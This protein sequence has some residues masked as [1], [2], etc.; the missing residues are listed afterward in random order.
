MRISSGECGHGDQRDSR[1]LPLQVLQVSLQVVVS[2]GAGLQVIVYLTD[3]LWS[4]TVY[5]VRI[6]SDDYD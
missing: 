6:T 1:V 5:D 4:Y 3:L 2:R